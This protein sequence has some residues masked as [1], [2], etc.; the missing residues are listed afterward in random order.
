MQTL[1]DA[2]SLSALSDAGH[3]LAAIDAVIREGDRAE[4]ATTTV[5]SLADLRTVIATLAGEV[6]RLQ[7]DRE[8]MGR[9]LSRIANLEFRGGAE[10]LETRNWKRIVDEM[11]A[12]AEA[13]LQRR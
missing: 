8:R 2:K 7:A 13:G 10:L 3:A 5:G 9:Q 4:P 12:I 1:L 11:Q 6:Q